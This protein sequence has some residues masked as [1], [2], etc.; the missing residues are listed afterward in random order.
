MK[1]KS[2]IFAVQNHSNMTKKIFPLLLIAL[3]IG[4]CS[5]SGKFN[6]N[7]QITDAK[8]TMLYLEHLTLGD[9]IVA[10]DSVKLDEEGNFSFS[11]DTVGNPEFYRLRIGGQCIN[12]A[13]DS[14]ETV[15]VRAKLPNMSFGYQVEGSGVCDTIRLLSLK[16]ADLERSVLRTANDRHYTMQ[17][18]EQMIEDLI[19]QYK[20]EVKMEIIQNRYGATYSYFAC[21][22]MLG[23]RL[24]FNPM[25][26]KGDLTW[27]HAVANAWN[28]LYPGCQR[29]QNLFNIIVQCRRQ[30][31]KPHQIVLDLDDDRISEL[32]IIDMT[33]PDITGAERTLSSLK[34][35]V[36]LLDFTAFGMQGSNERT[37]ELRTLYN[38]YHAQGFE[39]Y[40][41]S[42]DPDRHFWTQRCEQLPWVSVYCEDGLNSDML[43]LYNVQRIPTYFLI[44]RNCDLKARMEDI[45]DLARAIEQLL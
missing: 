1:G 43:Q 18:R 19:A 12:L 31:A 36:V 10:I 13:I 2:I 27:L 4:S 45:P 6:I 44:D 26:D 39:I 14:T 5:K 20:D 40:Q 9:G 15:T 35:K 28:E 32:G 41:V 25:A 16:L 33:F 23:D 17:E 7:G 38:K 37:L 34:G 8:D 3:L 24:L 22:Q 11:A 29:T 30:H 21:F 42:V